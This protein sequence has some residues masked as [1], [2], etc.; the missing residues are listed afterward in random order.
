MN[1]NRTTGQHL[2]IFLLFFFL[3]N[4]RLQAQCEQVEKKYDK[5]TSGGGII[6]PSTN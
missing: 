2:T 1:T 3:L 4:A 6:V 5:L